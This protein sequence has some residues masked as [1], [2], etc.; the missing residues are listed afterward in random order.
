MIHID[1]YTITK[2]GSKYNAKK[3]KRENNQ[4]LFKTTSDDGMNGKRFMRML[5]DLDENINVYGCNVEINVTFTEV[6]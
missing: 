6:D 4:T 5:D 1:K 3:D 2:I